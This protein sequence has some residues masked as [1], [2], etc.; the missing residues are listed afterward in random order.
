MRTNAATSETIAPYAGTKQTVLRGCRPAPAGAA[1][2]IRLDDEHC[3][4]IGVMPQALAF[5]DDRVTIWTTV[6]TDT[7]KQAE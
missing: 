6:A 2:R 4:V 3:D 5:R 1:P 7:E